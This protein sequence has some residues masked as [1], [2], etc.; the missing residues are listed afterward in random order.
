MKKKLLIFLLSLLAVVLFTASVALVSAAAETDEKEWSGGTEPTAVECEQ[1][2]TIEVPTFTIP[3]PSQKVDH[4]VI[5]IANMYDY[6]TNEVH[7]Y[8]T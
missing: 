8:Y 3:N 4:Y 6:R 1:Y 2:E 5:V 7:S